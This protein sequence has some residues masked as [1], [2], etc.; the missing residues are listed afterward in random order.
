MSEELRPCPFCGED[1]HIERMGDSHQ[2]TI[3]E[4]DS[5]GCRLET[6]EEWGHGGAWNRRPMED[7]LYEDLKRGEDMYILMRNRCASVEAEIERIT[8]LADGLAKALSKN[9]LS[10]KSCGGYGKF[11]RGD[12]MEDC[13][14]CSGDVAALKAWCERDK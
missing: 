3:Y 14:Y 6:G 7:K 5:C 11:R 2:S 12:F 4:C 10:C 8:K 13:P 1:A 9:Q